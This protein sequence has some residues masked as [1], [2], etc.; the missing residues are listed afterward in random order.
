MKQEIGHRRTRNRAR[1]NARPAAQQ[2]GL[3]GFKAKISC[4]L[5]SDGSAAED[6]A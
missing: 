6:V 5:V 4:S 2:C 3:R 1:P